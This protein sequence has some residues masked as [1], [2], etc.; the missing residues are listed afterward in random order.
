MCEC[1]VEERR[2]G[3]ARC[4]N[5]GREDVDLGFHEPSAMYVCAPCGRALSELDLSRF[6][7]EA[8]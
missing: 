2:F 3:P 4:E 5:C 7:T 6:P 1:D 8:A